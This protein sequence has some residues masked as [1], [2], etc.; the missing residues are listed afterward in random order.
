MNGDSSKFRDFEEFTI[1]I[2]I[3]TG[4]SFVLIKIADYF[5]NNT[6]G[7][8]DNLQSFIAILVSG[9]L[10]ELVLISSFLILK[11]HLLFAKNK[12]KTEII[13][14][15]IFNIFSLF[16][17]F[18]G[19]FSCFLLF[20][21]IILSPKLT[22]SLH[23]TNI[24][25]AYIT[26]TGFAIFQVISYLIDI[27]LEDFKKLERKNLEI[28]GKF[29]W[30]KRIVVFIIVTTLFL[31]SIITPTY[32]LG[33]SYSIEVFPQSKTNNEMLTFTIKE[34]G[35]TSVRNYISLYKLDDNN[36]FQNVDG[37]IINNTHESSTK[38]KKMI[39]KWHEGSWYLKLNTSKLPHGNYMLHT[40]VTF[41]D[42]T[43]LGVFK[44][45]ADK[46]FYIPSKSMIY[47]FNST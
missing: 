42:L 22:E 13:A 23:Y 45:H 12:K 29:D 19:M 37:I 26:L 4:L 43:S 20:F 21:I 28:L 1:A 25:V 14:N 47:S 2:T 35:I 7:L 39:G 32:L 16:F 24:F 41:S 30:K 6:I 15:T 9:L 36:F 40:E 27:K 17:V 38:D 3:L 34:T 8:S 46:L 18:L 5:N 33:G 11:G 44:K 31:L 10:L